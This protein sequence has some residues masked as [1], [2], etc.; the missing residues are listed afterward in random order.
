MP[1]KILRSHLMEGDIISLSTKLS[2]SLFIFSGPL[3]YNLLHQNLPESLPSL[4]TVQRM[5]CKDY[6]HITEGEFRFDM[7][8]KHIEFY[9]GPKIIAIGEDATRVVQRVQYDPETNKMVGFVLP[10]TEEA[11]QKQIHSWLHHLIK[12][13]N[14][15][16]FL[17]LL[18]THLC[19]WLHHYL[20]I[21]Q[22][23]V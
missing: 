12:C 14:V 9:K 8:V 10:C 15:L 1:L 4:R 16:Q 7:L 3:A 6:S 20:S 19:I 13:S 18:I 5:M 2:L 11:Y 23:F 17:K 21:Y 22:H